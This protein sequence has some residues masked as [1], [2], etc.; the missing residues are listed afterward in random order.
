[1]EKMRKENQKVNKGGERGFRTHEV[2]NVPKLAPI[3]K[4][5]PVPK[6]APT[7]KLALWPKLAPMPNFAQCGFWHPGAN[8]PA[9]LFFS[10]SSSAPVFLLFCS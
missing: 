8:F 1:M 7:P 9:A 10:Y 3:P 4:L 2:G 5:A 6:L